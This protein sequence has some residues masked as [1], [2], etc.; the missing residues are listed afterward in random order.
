MFNFFRQLCINGVEMTV[1]PYY[2]NPQVLDVE[3]KRGDKNMS[4]CVD[5]SR[6]DDYAG[7]FNKALVMIL[8]QYL[9]T[10]LMESKRAPEP[11]SKETELTNAP[12]LPTPKKT[13]PKDK[14]RGVE[15]SWSNPQRFNS[16]DEMALYYK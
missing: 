13:K 8:E 15:G 10:F 6:L 11:V 4:C 12:G 9:N 2:K 14:N 16:L 1:G 3:F 7:D 5:L